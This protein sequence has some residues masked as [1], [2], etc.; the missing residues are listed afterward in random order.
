[1]SKF[2]AWCEFH[3]CDPKEKLE[4]PNNIWLLMEDA[5]ENHGEA[6]VSELLTKVFQSYP[7][8]FWGSFNE[9]F[10]EIEFIAFDTVFGIDA[11]GEFN[12]W[13]RSHVEFSGGLVLNFEEFS[14]IFNFQTKPVPRFHKK[15]KKPPIRKKTDVVV[16]YENGSTYTIKSVENV[17]FEIDRCVISKRDFTAPGVQARLALLLKDVEKLLIKSPKGVITASLSEGEIHSDSGEVMTIGR[18]FFY[19][20]KNK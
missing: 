5:I 17:L 9:F 1:M 19:S 7:C 16:F 13:S 4:N 15:R 20:F 18:S 2:E 6:V 12:G 14:S 10:S 8:S 3:G 11:Q